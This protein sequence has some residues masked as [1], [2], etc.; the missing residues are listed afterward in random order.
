M[1]RLKHILNQDFSST[2]LTE[3]VVVGV[4]KTVCVSSR[5]Y[6]LYLI[7]LLVQQCLQ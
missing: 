7:L 3:S 1:Q 6:R 4:V 2:N 5:S